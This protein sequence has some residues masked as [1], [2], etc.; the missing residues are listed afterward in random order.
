MVHRRQLDGKEI[1]LGN[2]GAL[3]GNAMTWWDHDTG[4]VW[5]QPLGE[6]ILGPRKGETLELFASTLTT[7]AAWKES[8]PES[9]ALDVAGWAT[10][11][12]LEDMAV[13]VD[14]GSESAA[15]LIPQLR[16]AGVVNTTVAGLDIAVVIDPGDPSRWAV[17]SRHLDDQ[18]VELEL[19]DG[20]LV[21]TVTGTA[22]DP[23][24]GR[25]R[26][27]PLAGQAL[28]RLPAF[29]AFPEDFVTFFPNGSIWP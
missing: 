14:R 25:G 1:V 28:D 10:G 20:D 18:V 17:F 27:G 9:L 22:F 2:E 8:H 4:S 29:T 5:S 19:I 16:E 12:H 3:F 24:I 26:S 15:F 6:A 11:F 21:D 7:W 23:F 13:V